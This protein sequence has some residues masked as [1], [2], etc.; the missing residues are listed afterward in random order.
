MESSNDSLSFMKSDVED[1]LDKIKMNTPLIVKEILIGS[2][3]SNYGGTIYSEST[4]YIYI[5]VKLI[6]LVDSKIKLYIKIY[7]PDGLET[8]NSSPN[9][10]TYSHDINVEPNEFC[11]VDLAGWGNKEPGHYK[12]GNYR[13]EL[14]FKGTCVGL[15]TFKVSTR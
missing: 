11:N 2:N 3:E 13:L 9:G 7:G 4:T 1:L 14:Y 12:V 15:K 10:F 8:G 6:S 5:Q